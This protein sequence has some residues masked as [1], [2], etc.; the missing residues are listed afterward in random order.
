MKTTKYDTFSYCKLCSKKQ[1]SVLLSVMKELNC[2][3]NEERIKNSFVFLTLFN[4]CFSGYDNGLVPTS[5]KTRVF[6][7]VFICLYSYQETRMEKIVFCFSLWRTHSCDQYLDPKQIRCVYHYIRTDTT[8]SPSI[9]QL[10]TVCFLTTK[11][12]K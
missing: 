5:I 10:F 7:P 1:S 3:F 12:K 9:Q 6:V 2:I 8:L 4:V 11:K